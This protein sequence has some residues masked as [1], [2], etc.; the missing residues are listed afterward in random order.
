M[1]NIKKI[2]LAASVIAA[3]GVST[4]FASEDTT[5]NP[6]R[7]RDKVIASQ[8]AQ[9]EEKPLGYKNIGRNRGPHQGVRHH[10][11]FKSLAEVTGKE[12]AAIKEECKTNKLNPFQYAQK[13]GK[14][15][16]YKAKR[17]EYIKTSLDKAVKDGKITQDKADNFLDRAGK[18]MDDR[19]DGKMPPHRNDKFRDHRMGGKQGPRGGRNL[20]TL[21]AVTGKSE[22]D[23]MDTCREQKIN[24]CQYAAKEGKY[25]EY[26]AKRMK[27]VK[28]R[29]DKAVKNGKITQ[30]KADEGLNRMSKIMD[31]MK[32]GKMPQRPNGVGAGHRFNPMHP[33]PVIPQ[34]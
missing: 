12:E 30:A 34:K 21:A 1:K 15:A 8:Q 24:P 20:K 17:L 33:G 14:Y 3:L 26:K 19:R 31:D 6:H 11:V 10:D 4:A 16:E 7:M 27:E 23:I 13:E 18:A 25:E 28:A 9:N 29:L 2:A 32:D 5:V 22:K